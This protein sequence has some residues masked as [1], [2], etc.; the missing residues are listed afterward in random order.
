MHLKRW[1]TAIVLIPVLI[2]IIGFSNP[3]AFHILLLLI[4]I[5]SINEF[6]RM[7]GGKG[8]LELFLVHY[9]PAILLFTIAYMR[10][11]L[12]IPPVIML[13]LF[14]PVILRL[15]GVR[16]SIPNNPQGISINLF[17]PVYICLP[18]LMLA[19]I[20]LRPSG[21]MWVFFILLTV[22]AN[23]TGAFY[24]GRLMGR[25]KLHAA[26]SPKKTIEGA[27]GGLLTGMIAG[28]YFL[29]IWKIQA[30]NPSIIILILIICI[31][32]QF[33]DLAESMLKSDYGVK[34]TGSILPGHGGFLDRID[35]LLF[36]IPVLYVYLLLL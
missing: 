14:I 35:G 11:V 6:C 26:V 17:I 3:L 20:Y 29:K 9:F 31:A 13:W 18:N 30:V 2:Y 5:I 24:L 8:H 32:G 21:R 34:Y 19:M 27:L 25:H 1:I 22:F 10:R 16:T 23:D 7:A 36:S 12:L 4:S 33:G 28:V 15:L